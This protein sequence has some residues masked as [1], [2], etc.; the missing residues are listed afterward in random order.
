MHVDGIVA[1][2]MNINDSCGM[3]AIAILDI[4][5]YIAASG[6]RPFFFRVAQ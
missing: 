1:C 3:S 4:V 2:I 6:H 5:I